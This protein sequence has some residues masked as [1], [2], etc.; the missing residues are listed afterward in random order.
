LFVD[1]ENGC[2]FTVKVRVNRGKAR[3]VS[4]SENY[5]VVELTSKPQNQQANEELIKFLSHVLGS[6]VKLLTGHR[7]K[8]KKIFVSSVSS[9]E[10]AKRLL[11]AISD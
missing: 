5:V 4:A 1:T 2:I 3:V 8:V 11:D 7:S 9:K 6:G 10:C